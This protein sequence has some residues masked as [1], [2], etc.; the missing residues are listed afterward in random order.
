ME[1]LSGLRQKKNEVEGR[2]LILSLESNLGRIE[3]QL[4]NLSKSE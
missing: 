3:A 4:L 2:D 1:V